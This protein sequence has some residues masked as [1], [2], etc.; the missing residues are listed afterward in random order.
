MFTITF[1]KKCFYILSPYRSQW[2]VKG[3]NICMH[4]IICFILIDLIMPHDYFQ[5]RK[6]I[7]LLSVSVRVKHLLICY[8]KLLKFDMQHDHILKKLILFY[9]G[10][11]LAPGEEFEKNILSGALV[12]LLF[13]GVEPFVQF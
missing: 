10:G 12:A 11:F 8:C 13:R 9:M 3:Q 5:K 2:C 1:R 4:G 7:N 6:Q